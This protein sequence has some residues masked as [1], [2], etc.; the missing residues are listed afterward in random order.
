MPQEAISV[1]A[2]TFLLIMAPTLLPNKLETGGSVAVY[3]YQLVLMQFDYEQ[4][5]LILWEN[6]Y[7][8]ILAVEKKFVGKGPY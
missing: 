1:S 3:N 8:S 5:T 7:S 2:Q 6:A 4:G